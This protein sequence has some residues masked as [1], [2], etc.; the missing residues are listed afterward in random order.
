MGSNAIALSIPF[1]HHEEFSV[2]KI[3]Q[4]LHGSGLVITSAEP[5]SCATQIRLACGAVINVFTTGTVVVQGSVD[6]RFRQ[7]LL[8]LLQQVLP[9]NTT[10]CL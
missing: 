5:I 9:A 7:R 3:L 6:K 8:H 2:S 10:W 4:N 1:N